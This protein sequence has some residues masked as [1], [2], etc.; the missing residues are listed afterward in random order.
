MI[1]HV[2]HAAIWITMRLVNPAL[3][4]VLTIFNVALHEIKHTFPFERQQ[5]LFI[6]KQTNEKTT[7]TERNDW[8]SKAEAKAY[9]MSKARFSREVE[10][11]VSEPVLSSVLSSVVRRSST[12][13]LGGR[14]PKNRGH[15]RSHYRGHH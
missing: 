9:K 12:R 14:P 3:T 8:D 7:S 1:D 6:T 11:E 2:M 15:V 4:L 13:S 10:V 5:K